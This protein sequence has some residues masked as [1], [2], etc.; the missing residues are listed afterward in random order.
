MTEILSFTASATHHTHRFGAFTIT[1]VQ[2]T[3]TGKEHVIL[4]KGEVAGKKGVVVRVASECLPGTALDS[5]DCEC[6][7]QIDLALEIIAAKGEGVFILLRQ[8]G[9]GHGLAKKIAALANKNKG[10]DTFTAVEMLGLPADIRT[11][12]EAAEILRKL[13]VESI[14]LL[15]NNPLKVEELEKEGVVIEQISPLEVAPTPTTLQH[16]IAKK[17]RGHHLSMV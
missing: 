13:Q 16:L 11:Y 8:E 6:K 9:R 2:N 15:T 3:Q 10:Y 4:V 14:H 5:A 1:T 7:D 12:S 17:L